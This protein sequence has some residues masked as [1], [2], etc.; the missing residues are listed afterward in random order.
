MGTAKK[1]TDF[2]TIIGLFAGIAIIF[3][4]I[5]QSGGSLV[6]F[7]NINSILKK[8]QILLKSLMMWITKESL[9]VK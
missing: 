9:I 1:G 4:G 6:W 2:G 3:L 7:Y 5:I 8:E